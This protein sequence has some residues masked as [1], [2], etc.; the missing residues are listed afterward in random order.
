MPD[1][2]DIA[3]IIDKTKVAAENGRRAPGESGD[4]LPVAGSA[5][6]EIMLCHKGTPGC[7]DFLQEV[8]CSQGREAVW[9]L[10]AFPAFRKEGSEII[11]STMRDFLS[12]IGRG[13]LTKERQRFRV[14]NAYLQSDKSAELQYEPSGRKDLRPIYHRHLH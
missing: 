10:A 4:L 6:D 12:S 9:S 13:A 7:G 14:Q 3:S 5:R 1:A 11:I 8:F 2:C